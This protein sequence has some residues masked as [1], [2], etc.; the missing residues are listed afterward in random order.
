[1]SRAIRLGAAAFAAAGLLTACSGTGTTVEQPTTQSSATATSSSA[2]AGQGE[3]PRV[4]AP[5]PVDGLLAQ[6]CSALSPVQTDELGMVKPERLQGSIGPSCRW[7]SASNDANTVTVS[8]M[9]ANKG[10]LG[11]IYANKAGSVYFE[12]TQ[13]DGYPA[14]YADIQD[15]R[16]HGTCSL[17][18]GVT[19]QLA[20]SVMPQI[21][22]G[23]NASNPCPVA[24]RTAKAMTEHL[25]GAA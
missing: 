13:I 5:L 24:E 17:W 18:V 3:A 7:T 8:A 23:S 11:D 12:P 25:K 15:G 9:T 6:P 20:V 4:P 2:A 1:M 14:V 16:P 22:R 10:G 19:D 21:L